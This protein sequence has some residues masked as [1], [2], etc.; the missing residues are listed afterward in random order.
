[1]SATEEDE[2]SAEVLPPEHTLPP[3]T[4]VTPRGSVATG[5]LAL[6][7]LEV[8]LPIAAASPPELLSPPIA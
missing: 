4:E 3:I 7:T 6:P 8:L 2:R 1:M 5:V